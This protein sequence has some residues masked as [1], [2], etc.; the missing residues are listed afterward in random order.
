MTKFTLSAIYNKIAGGIFIV[1]YVDVLYVINFF[2]TF[3]LLLATARFT[4]KG[5]NT[6]RFIISSALGGAYSLIIIADVSEL[7]STVSKVIASAVIVLVAFRFT[8][9]SS[10]FKTYIVF[11]VMNFLFL[12]VIYGLS[13]LLKTPYIQLARGTVYLDISA[14]GLLLSAFFAYIVSSLVIRIYNRR[15]AS[16]EVLDITVEND[17]KSVTLS[18]LS[19]TGNKLREPFSDYPVIIADRALLN[20]VSDGK[21]TRLIPAS[22]VSGNSFMLSFKPDRVSVKTSRGNEEIENVYIALSDDM[23]SDDFSAVINPEILS[24]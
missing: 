16:G 14:R 6:L 12:G 22:T 18:A 8:G 15:L 2:I 20:G 17:G 3:L 1:I 24:V 21:S 5:R 10:F 13:L 7:F 4:K 23:K 9:V 19:D 11:Y